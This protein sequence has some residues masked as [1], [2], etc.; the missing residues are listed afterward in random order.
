MQKSTLAPILL[1]LICLCLPSSSMA[2]AA[3]SHGSLGN[4]QPVV[5]VAR[6][7]KKIHGLIN[8]E[9]KKA[10]LPELAWNPAL[11]RIA[12]DYSREMA[13][14][15]FFSHTGPDG[16]GFAERY[17]DAG[18]D[19]AL[20]T[21]TDAIC[22]GGEN[23]ALNALYNSIVWKNGRSKTA[24]NSEGQIAA[25]VVRQWMA[26]PG[27]RRNIL[28]SHYRRQGIGIFIDHNGRVLVTENFC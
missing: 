16:R 5:D 12:R 23:L 24:W 13:S 4:R 10:G 11:Q 2:G 22:L 20:R 21:S 18:F 15:N 7:E 26:S 27:H 6:L 14:R 17:Q 25:S 8:Q 3:T 28:T 19:C 1:L 9:R